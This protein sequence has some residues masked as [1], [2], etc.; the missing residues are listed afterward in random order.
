VRALF[1]FFALFG[2][3]I[4]FVQSMALESLL[5]YNLQYKVYLG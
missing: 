3:K 1:S 2:L 5:Y 4:E